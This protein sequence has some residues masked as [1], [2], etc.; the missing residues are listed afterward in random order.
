V[1]GKKPASGNYSSLNGV[2]FA[3]MLYRL[4]KTGQCGAIFRTGP[5]NTGSINGPTGFEEGH[6]MGR[7]IKALVVLVIFGFIA[8]T[9]YAYLADLAPTQGEVKKPV[10]LN[11]D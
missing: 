8:L 5:G 1:P 10:V 4:C 2:N 11:A 7:I 3:R 9:G 6:A